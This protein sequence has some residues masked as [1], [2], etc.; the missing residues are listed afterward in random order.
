MMSDKPSYFR[1]GDELGDK[2]MLISM[3]Y[4]TGHIS[5]DDV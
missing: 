2:F 4:E 3:M 1:L 5:I